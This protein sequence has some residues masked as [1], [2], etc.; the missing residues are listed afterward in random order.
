MWGSEVRILSPRPF[1][2]KDLGGI[3]AGLTIRMFRRSKHIASAGAAFAV[4]A[5]VPEKPQPHMHLVGAPSTTLEI[6]G[7]FGGV[8]PAMRRLG[9]GGERPCHWLRHGGAPCAAFKDL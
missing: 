6:S 4:K 3:G 9:V 7:R 5:T 1:L 8:T 2:F